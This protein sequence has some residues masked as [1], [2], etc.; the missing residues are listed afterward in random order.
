[1]TSIVHTLLGDG[2][3]DSVLEYPIK[4]ALG[5]LGMRGSDVGLADLS[6][7]DPRPRTLRDKV[8]ATLRLYPGT[9]ILYVHRDAEK[10]PREA[11]I[12]EIDDAVADAA[13]GDWSGCSVPIVPVRM[14]E[15]WLLHDEQAIREAS[16][17]RKGKVPLTLPSVSKTESV[18][19]P[20]QVLLD[21]LVDAS[22]RKGRRLH[23]LRREFGRFRADTARTIKDYSALK[24]VPAFQAFL[25]DLDTAIGKLRQAGRIE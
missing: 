3:S 18:A 23:D 1:M 16:G 22:E 9:H 13:V 15:A 6:V 25:R 7:V 12:E 21:A 10:E 2:S 19:D 20:K 14:T 8:S 24:A 17:N 5:E 4:W 11:R